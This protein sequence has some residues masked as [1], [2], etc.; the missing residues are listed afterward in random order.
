MGPGSVGRTGAHQ[1]H[2]PA[3]FIKQGL[4]ELLRVLAL[5]LDG[6]LAVSNA[7]VDGLLGTI[8]SLIQ[9]MFAPAADGTRPTPVFSASR[10]ISRCCRGCTTCCL[11]SH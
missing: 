1:R 7:F 4:A 8:A 5:L 3:D 10:W 9:T 6:A 2:V 11:A